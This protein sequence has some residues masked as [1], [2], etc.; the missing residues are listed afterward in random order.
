MHQKKAILVV[1][2][3]CET[4]RRAAD[5]K[6][7][8]I[9]RL[10]CKRRQREFSIDWDSWW[11]TDVEKQS[12][13]FPRWLNQTGSNTSTGFWCRQLDFFN[14]THN[15]AQAAGGLPYQV[16]SCIPLVVTGLR[17]CY[18]GWPSRLQP[19]NSTVFSLCSAT[20]PSLLPVCSALNISDTSVSLHWLHVAQRINFMPATIVHWS[21]HDTTP[22]YF[23]NDIHWHLDIPSISRP[24]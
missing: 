16:S 13:H 10:H 22:R 6:Q 5:G 8:E 23:V 12:G 19:T 3:H 14:G 20:Q 11:T 21:L 2:S 9:F 15:T 18:I 17:K 1:S 7:K 4:R 24:R